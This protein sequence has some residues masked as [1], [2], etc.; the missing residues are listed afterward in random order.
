VSD[1]VAD[2]RSRGFVRDLARLL[3]EDLRAAFGSRIRVEPRG[4]LGGG[5]VHVLVRVRLSGEDLPAGWPAEAVVRLAPEA[6]GE[7]RAHREHMTLEF[8]RTQGFPAV[9]A[10]RNGV[11]DGRAYLLL[12]FIDAP[13]TTLHFLLP[14][15]RGRT[16][17]ILADLHAR[18]HRLPVS[19]WPQPSVV[20]T[21]DRWIEEME[22]ASAKRS[23]LDV[24]P[25]IEWLRAN[26]GLAS[27][28][29][30]A[31]CHFDFAPSNVLMRWRGAPVVVDW[32]LAALGDPMCDLAFTLEKLVLVAGAVPGPVRPLARALLGADGSY[33]SAY[34]ARAPVDERRLR[35]WRAGYC[36]LARLWAAGLTV[37]GMRLRT[38]AP[39]GL[40]RLAVLAAERF[41]AIT[42]TRE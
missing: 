20:R 1:L 7:P 17:A 19:G 36:V 5:F 26:R 18:L 40:R 15:R 24:G 16:M 23:D 6:T 28:Q 11:L 38:S 10:L 41:R 8:C 2:Q 9:R 27:F 31:V 3:Q 29:D 21:A 13:E 33:E 37:A 14:W 32:D 25:A 30:A 39:A 22:Q 35:Y 4:T 34:A 42:G 12:E